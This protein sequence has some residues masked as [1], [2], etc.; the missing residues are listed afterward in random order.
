MLGDPHPRSAHRAIPGGGPAL[1]NRQTPARR[2]L[3]G[4]GTARRP[5]DG[6]G[7]AQHGLPG[8]RLARHQFKAHRFRG[9]KFRAQRFKDQRLTI[10]RLIDRR[11]AGRWTGATGGQRHARPLDPHAPQQALQLVMSGLGVLIIASIVALSAFFVIAD[12][13]SDP[14]ARSAA[15]AAVDSRATDAAPLTQREVF[16]GTEIRPASGAAPYQIVMTH[17]D[18]DCPTATTGELGALLDTYGCDQVVRAG[19]LAPYG[20]YRVTAG[21]FNLADARGAALA[22]EQI[23]TLVESGR[24]SFA[25]MGGLASDPLAEPLA[26]VGWRQHGHF[27]VYCVIARPDGGLVADDDRTA[28]RIAADLVEQYLPETVLGRRAPAA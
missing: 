1:L 6:P 16:P 15:P 22:G 18:T 20:G 25:A 9:H 23:G 11:L 17:I 28:Q 2:A 12:R 13:L 27:L 10:H 8:H 26:Q 7:L 4:P 5:F 24:G 21:I 19:L 3:D 14:I